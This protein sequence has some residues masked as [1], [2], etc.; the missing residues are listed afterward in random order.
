MDPAPRAASPVVHPIADNPGTPA[1]LTAVMPA[2][3]AAT[4]L[5]VFLI[6]EVNIESP[7]LIKN[8]NCYHCLHGGA[9][10]MSTR[11]DPRTRLVGK[12]KKYWMFLSA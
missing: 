11:L 9:T 2:L 1:R 5:V 3:P 10:K 8:K 6:I 12:S 4:V 7:F